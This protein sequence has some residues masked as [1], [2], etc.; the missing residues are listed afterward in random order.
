MVDKS[1]IAHL[2]SE[3]GI[4]TDNIEPIIS[5]EVETIGGKYLIPKVIGTVIWS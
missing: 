1:S 5:N 3:E 2:C 4:F